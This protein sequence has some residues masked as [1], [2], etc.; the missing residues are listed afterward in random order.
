MKSN[1]SR[2]F[3]PDGDDGNNPPVVPPV[4]PPVEPL[5]PRSI[6]KPPKP[7]KEKD[8]D[9]EIINLQKKIN[10]LEDAKTASDAV[11]SDLKKLVEAAKAAPG[12]T[13][14]KSILDDLNEYL[15]FGE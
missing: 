13:K 15:G 2:L 12:K 10:L 8:Y 6:P 4:V 9:G 7:P 3:S 1:F 5:G 14:G 11:V